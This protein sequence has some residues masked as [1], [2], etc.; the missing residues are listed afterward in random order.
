MIIPRTLSRRVMLEASRSSSSFLRPWCTLHNQAS[1]MR[2]LRLGMY[3]VV[4][5][6]TGLRSK[7]EYGRVKIRC[8][9]F[10]ADFAAKHPD[11]RYTILRPTGIV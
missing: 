11:F 2:D 4:V 5:V 6:L 9:H 10:L 1:L 7:Y 8:E 3:L